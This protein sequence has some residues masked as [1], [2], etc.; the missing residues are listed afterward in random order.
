[1]QALLLPTALAGL[2]ALAVV[3]STASMTTVVVV[4]FALVVLVG[5]ADHIKVS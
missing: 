3:L 2:L 5:I 4:M 1:M